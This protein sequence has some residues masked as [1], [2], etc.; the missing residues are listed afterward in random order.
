M[1]AQSV[2][3]DS[4]QVTQ[5]IGIYLDELRKTSQNTDKTVT[6][7]ASM[8][9]NLVEAVK[10]LDRHPQGIQF[11]SQWYTQATHKPETNIHIFLRELWQKLLQDKAQILVIANEHLRQCIWK[12]LLG[13]VV[14][15]TP[16]ILFVVLL[17]FIMNPV[18]FVPVL[19]L[20]CVLLPLLGHF[21]LISNGIADLHAN[22]VLKHI[23]SRSHLDDA[24]CRAR[25][26]SES[27][28]DPLRE[29][30]QEQYNFPATPHLPAV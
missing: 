16:P 22:K 6:D 9:E 15:I 21:L 27:Q 26:F 7:W 24:G 14:C 3:T 25:F 13:L 29:S 19:L 12:I 11:I 30:I 17:P 18:V 4:M 28:Y 23:V 2:L 20:T 8:M 5:A 10:I 1:Q